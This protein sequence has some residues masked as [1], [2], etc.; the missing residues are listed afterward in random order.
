M[1]KL[2]RVSMLIALAA[3]AAAGAAMG[4]EMSP[5]QQQAMMK[6]M[7]P[8]VHHKHLAQFAGKFEYTSK[9]WMS[10]GGQP[11]ESKG[12]S[13]AEMVM[14]GRYLQDE[15][16]GDV[17]GMPF[18]GM[19]LTGYDNLAGE[20]TFAWIDNMSTSIMRGAGSCSSDGK[21]ITLEGTIL[22][23]GVPEPKPFKQVVTW[24]DEN[25]HTMDWYMPSEKGEMFKTM[26]LKYTRVK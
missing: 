22:A 13:V 20:Y 16:A 3:V 15:V 18:K 2:I 10:P 19:G 24:V 26:E 6:A 25:H 12:T 1:R 5:E 4:Q 17:M 21:V 11:M 23:P 7:T 8:G 9:M 14:G